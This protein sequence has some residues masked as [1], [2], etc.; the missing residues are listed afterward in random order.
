MKIMSCGSESNSSLEIVPQIRGN[1]FKSDKKSAFL[2][3]FDSRFR[4]LLDFKRSQ[5]GLGNIYI[6]IQLFNRMTE[7]KKKQKKKQ[8][9]AV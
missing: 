6:V 1:G 4:G 5:G 7:C 8:D 9:K 3:C 2:V